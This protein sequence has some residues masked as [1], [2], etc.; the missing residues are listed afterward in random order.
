MSSKLLF[1]RKKFQAQF[2]GLLSFSL[3]AMTS[4][5][6]VIFTEIQYNAQ[7]GKP[8]FIE[9]KNITGTPLDMGTWFFSDGINYTFP[10]FNPADT[11]AHIFQPHEIILVSPVSESDLRTAY[12]SIP[13][14]IRIFGPYTGA[15]SNSGEN[16]SLSDKNGVIMTTIDYNDG[17]KW[18]PSADGTGHT[19][20]R[21]NPNLSNREWRNW[22]ASSGIGGTPGEE[23]VISTSSLLVISEVHFGPDGNT[24]W[25]ELHAP[26]AFPVGA[27]P[28]KLSSTK[29]L[30]DAVSLSGTIPA[31]GYQSFPAVFTP[32]ENG[33][34]N[35]FLSGGV[36][37]L[38][39]ARL[40]RDHGEESF[41]FF[42]GE[43]YGSTGHTQDAPND[44]VSRQTNIVINEIMYDAPSDQG[45]GEFIELYN[46]SG[47]AISL[48]GWKFT[49]GI[50]FEFPAGT[51]IEGNSYLVIAADS[52]SLLEG[53]PGVNVIG[54]WKGGLRDRGE[55]IRLIDANGNMADEVDYLT[56]G[57]WPNL[58]DGDGSSMELR[59][60]DMDNNIATAWAD[61]D[62]SQK[63][64]MQTFTF[65]EDFRRQPWLPLSGNQ[66]LHAHLVGDSHVIIENVEIKRN[67]SGANLVQNPNNMSPNDQSSQ[68]WV[69]QG[70]HWSSFFDNGQLNLI[71]DGHGDN[72]GNGA[73]VDTTAFTFGESYTLTFDARWVS[74]KS[75]IIF[76]TLDHGFGTSFL[77]PIPAN[78]GTPGAPN[79]QVQASA[80]P[81]V[82]GV[83][84][85]PA[86]PK[87]SETVTITAQVDSANAI[88]AVDLVYRLDTTGGNGDW[89]RSP[90]TDTGDGLY[91]V[92]SNQFASQGNIIEFYV[93]A[94]SGTETTTQP[95]FGAGRP[96]MWIVD[97][98]TMPNTLLQER[99]I[100]SENDRRALTTSIGG[101]AE[102]NYNFPKTSNHFYNATFIA[103]ESEIYYNAEL[104]KSGSPFTRADN[105]AID[106]GK[107]KLPG[108]RLFRGRRRN[109]IDASGTAQGS[110]TPRFSNI[111]RQKTA[112]FVLICGRTDVLRS[113]FG[114]VGRTLV[115]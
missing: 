10:D 47:D 46:R 64:S 51:I 93:E 72:K 52:A 44:P 58:A 86:V 15:L 102:F 32:D 50:S 21:I 31:G 4:A 1:L 2:I 5:E 49:S 61:S 53:N 101:S 63:S 65:T 70:T 75:R 79:S 9:I 89:L 73:E 91:S 17:G 54:D 87:A 23:N 115:W 26:N 103:N 37:V 42:D 105:S 97:S 29:S 108:D 71:A 77:L 55:L 24:D 96:A 48:S 74:G 62:E 33:D 82:S 106:H 67:N 60:P 92:T 18:P 22:T 25:I 59:H 38:S 11:D 27:T 111:I 35:I 16:L 104:R 66:E 109:V 14:D 76:Q 43:F 110:N 7:A 56:E 90:M 81:T 88:T 107:W 45:T 100:I 30:S 95:R 20:S 113:E 98:R 19:L 40:D 12:P 39:A 28:F 34:L 80:A 13:A 6:Q 99:F 41:Q 85:S 69:C 112:A 78:L 57:D 8:E 83:I 94:A 114:L 3:A 68:G 84:H 36:T